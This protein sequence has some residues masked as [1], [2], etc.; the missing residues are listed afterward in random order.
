MRQYL[1]AKTG[2]RAAGRYHRMSKTL[3]DDYEETGVKLGE[4]GYAE[5][6]EVRDKGSQS[7]FALKRLKLR[8][9]EGRRVRTECQAF[10]AMDHPHVVRLMDVYESKSELELVMEHMKGGELFDR[11]S[12]KGTY[13]DSEASGAM[14]QMLL[15]V[16]YLHENGIVHRDLKLQNFVYESETSSHVKLIDFGF[17]KV[18]VEKGM[19]MTERLGTPGYMAPEVLDRS[20]T[21]KCDVW[22]LGVIAF[23][24]VAGFTPFSNSSMSESA[25]EAS[26]RSRKYQLKDQKRIDL[27]EA[28]S[29]EAKK[30][31]DKLLTVEPAQRPTAAE[32]LQDAWITEYNTELEVAESHIDPCIV[33]AMMSFPKTPPF[34]RACMFASAGLVS[35]DNAKLID[36]FIEM[37]QDRNRKISKSEFKKAMRDKA[38]CNQSD[39]E[40]A[41]TALDVNKSG[42]IGY[43]EFLA[44]MPLSQ[45]LVLDKTAL[46]QTFRRLDTD[47]SGFL[48]IDNLLETVPEELMDE[49]DLT[50]SIRI[51]RT[52]FVD[53]FGLDFSEEHLA[54]R[55]REEHL[56]K[57][58]RRRTGGLH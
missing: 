25:I 15:A 11:V 52:D 40:A 41:F 24:L 53:G 8:G 34:K 17:S 19:K 21:S 48:T 27:W 13:S 23:V 20:Y 45:K 58:K 32:A 16:S 4:G 29:C 55:K 35:V 9:N 28:V 14:S 12:S 57:R 43:S 26:I 22:S 7:T 50:P 3:K 33:D 42:K 10:L 2:R 6:F 38:Q 36:A 54:K 56:A 18:C 37:D 30:F 1:L 46:Q 5:V 44:A 39:V 51:S 31:I 49:M 47:G